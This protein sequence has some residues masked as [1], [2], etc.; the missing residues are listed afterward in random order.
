MHDGLNNIEKEQVRKDDKKTKMDR[1]IQ[2][3]H[4]RN[5][6]FNNFQLCSMVDPSILATPAFRLLEEDFKSAI[7][8]G[9]TYICDI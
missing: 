3:S 4:Q 1:Y 2:T 5:S 6:I 7:Q 9:P 8:E